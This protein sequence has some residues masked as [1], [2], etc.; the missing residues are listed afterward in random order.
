MRPSPRKP[1]AHSTSENSERTHPL[2]HESRPRVPSV[3]AIMTSVANQMNVF[4]ASFSPIRSFQLRIPRASSTATAASAADVVSRPM[5]GPKIHAASSTTDTMAIAVS[6][7]VTGPSRAS[8][9]FASSGASG[10]IALPGGHRRATTSGTT[11]RLTSP[12][13]KAACAHPTHVITMPCAA[14]SCA[15]S[16]LATMAVRNIALVITV[17]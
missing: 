9:S 7:R 15:T 5:R 2:Y 6:R 13:T 10:L 14:A 1:G 3:L 16:G 8:A 17:P 11:M 4:Q 12:G